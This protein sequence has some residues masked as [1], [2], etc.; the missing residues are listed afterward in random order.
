MV[1][2][3]TLEKV[4]SSQNKSIIWKLEPVTVEYISGERTP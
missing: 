3:K 1:L 2:E 4:R